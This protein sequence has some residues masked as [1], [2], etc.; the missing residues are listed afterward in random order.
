MVASP[1][2]GS[3]A[4]SSATCARMRAASA[5]PSILVAAKPE[6]GKLDV[7]DVEAERL[8]EPHALLEVLAEPRGVARF[9]RAA[10]QAAFAGPP[11]RVRDEDRQHA[12]GGLHQHR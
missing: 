2:G 10:D 7:A 8:G 4:T 12:V 5:A 1:I 3:A 9:H 11:H 6:L